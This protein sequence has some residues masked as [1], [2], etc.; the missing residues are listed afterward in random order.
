M[1]QAD[2]QEKLQHFAAGMVRWLLSSAPENAWQKD[3]AEHCR[4]LGEESLQLENLPSEIDQKNFAMAKAVPGIALFWLGIYTGTF[5]LVPG[6]ALGVFS[7]YVIANCV[8]KIFS[9]GQE[10][11]FFRTLIYYLLRMENADG[12]ISQAELS[13]LRGVIEFI[14]TSAKE[15]ELW[16]KAAQT[17]EGYKELAPEGSFT[18]E[19]K[20]K[21][22]S[23]CWSLALCDGLAD[24]EKEMFKTIGA[25]LNVSENKLEKVK[26]EV[27]KIFSEHEQTLWQAIKIARMLN[28]DIINRVDE[29]YKLTAL[30]SLKPLSR[31]TFEEE[32]AKTEVSIRA[33]PENTVIERDRII[34]ASYLLARI[35]SSSETDN[36]MAIREAFL[37]LSDE[38]H[39]SKKLEA[40]ISEINAT[41]KLF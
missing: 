40:A 11:R 24:S 21:I 15:K 22:L 35:F 38:E 30:V 26:Q 17:P 31:E 37:N 18:E 23:A 5:W 29:L 25:E 27:E 3:F 6:V 16:L 14:P 10:A 2:N 36:S 19:E 32:L 20:E 33:L 28:S 8:N 12:V 34:L 41:L 13:S 9:S 7:S 39:Y 4:K 1:N